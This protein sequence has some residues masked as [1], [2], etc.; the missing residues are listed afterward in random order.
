[1][2][3]RMYETP[4]MGGTSPV[5]EHPA[6]EPR[7]PRPSTEPRTTRPAEPRTTRPQT[8]GSRS[9]QPP[10]PR[11]VQEAAK[12]LTVAAKGFRDVTRGYLAEQARERPYVLLGGAAAV[13]FVLGGGLASRLTISLLVVGARMFGT[14]ILTK[15]I[16]G[17]LALGDDGASEANQP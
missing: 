1:M 12:D 3:S 7:V 9:P 15:V 2:T 10:S 6:H 17:E 14:R 11:A 4:P 16:E 5:P 8:P 13:G